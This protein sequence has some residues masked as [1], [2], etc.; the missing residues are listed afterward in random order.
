MVD[1]GT[2][3]IDQLQNDNPGLDVGIPLVF[4]AEFGDQ[5]SE[6]EPL[7]RDVVL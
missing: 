2:E 4:L 1:L 7:I 5:F 3:F 6:V